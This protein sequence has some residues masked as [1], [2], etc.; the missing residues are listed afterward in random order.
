MNSAQP[1]IRRVEVIIGPLLN[2]RTKGNSG[3]QE[4]VRIL[5]DGGTDSLRV[6]FTVHKHGLGTSTPTTVEIFNLSPA[7]RTALRTQGL[8]IV[9]NA[10]WATD[11]TLT[12]IFSGNINAA[13]SRREGPDIVTT[14]L[15]MDAGGALMRTYVPPP[16]TQGGGANTEMYAAPG[17]Q[18]SDVIINLASL[19]PD[20]TIHQVSVQL[21]SSLVIGSGGYS[22]YG[23]VVNCIDELARAYG[24][25]WTVLDGVFIAA[26]DG[27]P[28]QGPVIKVDSANGFLIR[29]EPVFSTV[30]QLTAG[31]IIQTVLHPHIVP[32]G[33]VELTSL[34]NPELSGD[35]LVTTVVHSG[36]THSSQWMTT[37]ETTLVGNTGL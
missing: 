33:V 26:M 3:T 5:S 9:L 10:G 35:Y 13:Y 34:V 36:D 23:L 28:L 8:G 12:K 17:E 29:V 30:F 19:L 14:L 24:F 7:L 18:L 20:V 22:F 16:P 11:E 2:W 4:V 15:C 32:E 25:T 1:W 21:D 37:S 31:V 27:R 6:R